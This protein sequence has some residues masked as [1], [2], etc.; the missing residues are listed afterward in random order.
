MSDLIKTGKQLE[1]EMN[2]SDFDFKQKFLV[3]PSGLDKLEKM[4]KE[5]VG[6]NVLHTVVQEP[7]KDVVSSVFARFKKEHDIED[8]DLNELI[9]RVKAKKELESKVKQ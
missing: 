4:L 3:L 1:K 7:V 9:A 2:N 6:D 8:V 5:E